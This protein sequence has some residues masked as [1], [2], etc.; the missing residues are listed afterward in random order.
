[1]RHDV[2]AEIGRVVPDVEP[3]LRLDQPT[4]SSRNALLR[5]SASGLQKEHSMLHSWTMTLP[6]GLVIFRRPARGTDRPACLIAT[7]GNSCSMSAATA[8]TNRSIS[9]A[10]LPSSCSM[11]AQ[12]L[13]WQLP[14][15][16][17]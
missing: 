13:H 7:F 9:P 2:V 8:L 17:F 14:C 15:Q 3:V 5:S 1:V 4:M 11:A 16:S 10:G 6:L 12:F